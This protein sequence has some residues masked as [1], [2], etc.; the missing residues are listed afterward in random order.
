MTGNLEDAI[1]LAGGKGTRLR[2]V[3]DDRPKP[4]ALIAG[5]PF[6]EWLLLMLRRQGIKRAVMCTGYRSET[7]ESQ[8]GNG[9][10]IGME[11][12]D[13]ERPTFLPRKMQDQ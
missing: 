6:M 4:M 13:A 12:T 5:R 2:G 11:I 7:V 8:F 1:I 10:D 9:Q 3:L